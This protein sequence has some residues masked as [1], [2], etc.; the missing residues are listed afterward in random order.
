MTSAAKIMK[1]FKTVDLDIG[2]GITLHLTYRPR[3][4]ADTAEEDE[5]RRLAAEDADENFQAIELCR[6]LTEWDLTGPV[7]VEDIPGHKLGSAVASETDPVPLDPAIVRFLPQPLI[8]AILAAVTVD[9]QP[10]PTK[11][12]RASQRRGSTPTSMKSNGTRDEPTLSPIGLTT[13]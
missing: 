1:E 2:W 9:A 7:P 4:I 3:Q 12:L 13:S 8:A 11:M 6:I 10:D 5:R